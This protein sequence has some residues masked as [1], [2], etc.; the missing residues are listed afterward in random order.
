MDAS[1]EPFRGLFG[2]VDYPAFLVQNF[3]SKI[4]LCSFFVHFIMERT[5]YAVFEEQLASRNLVA[6]MLFRVVRA[7]LLV[8]VGIIWY[9]K[10]EEDKIQKWKNRLANFLS[11]SIIAVQST[12]II[13][14][15]LTYSAVVFYDV[16]VVNTNHSGLTKHAGLACFT[17]KFVTPLIFFML[18][19][20]PVD[21][22]FLSYGICCVTVLVSAL[23][24]GDM[25][26]LLALFLYVFLCFV[27]FGDTLERNKK[28]CEIVAKLQFTLNENERLA[29]EAQALELRAMI[30][31]VAHDLK[32]VHYL[33]SSPL[34]II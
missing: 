7:I 29:V 18:K 30:G 16:F 8:L 5:V 1:A 26:Q 14:I 12:T 33:L 15:M 21:V 3:S 10:P 34:L 6:S 11:S 13:L 9:F 2:A 24:A 17:L 32:T 25:E 27:A 22:I 31:N 28:M 20:T 19:D 23:Y 4:L